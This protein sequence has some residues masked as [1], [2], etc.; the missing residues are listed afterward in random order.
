MDRLGLYFLLFIVA[1]V[2]SQFWLVWRTRNQ[3][4]RPAPRLDDV[5]NAKFLEQPRLILYFW[6]PGCHVCGTTSMVINPLL[7]TRKDIVKINALEERALA[8]RFG[9]LGTP[10][11][12]VI[13]EGRIE[14]VLTGSR[15]EQQIRDL[16]GAWGEDADDDGG[17]DP[18]PG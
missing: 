4:G 16:V 6:R 5:V 17:G 11:L 15:N 2:A 8:R 18:P 7:G 9:I 12:V 14:R 1:F 13:R 3:Q 10:T